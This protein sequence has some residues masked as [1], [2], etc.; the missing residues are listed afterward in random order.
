MNKPLAF[1]LSLSGSLLLA[2]C[3]AAPAPVS[4]KAARK[5]FRGSAMPPEVAAKIKARSAL[6]KPKTTPSQP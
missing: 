5:N 4:E 6:A 2:G 3:T 1:A